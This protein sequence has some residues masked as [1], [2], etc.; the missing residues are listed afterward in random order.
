VFDKA[1]ILIRSI[2]N[3]PFAHSRFDS[4]IIIGVISPTQLVPAKHWYQQK[5]KKWKGQT[6]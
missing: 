4:K 1:H 5:Q 2:Q 3:R 6:F